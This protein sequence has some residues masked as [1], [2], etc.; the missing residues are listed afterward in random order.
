MPHICRRAILQLE[1]FHFML[2]RVDWVIFESMR[3]HNVF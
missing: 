1:V 3:G 2:S